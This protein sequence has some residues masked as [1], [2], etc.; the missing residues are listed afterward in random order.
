M[1]M[2]LEMTKR[3]GRKQRM[4]EESKI[5]VCLIMKLDEIELS[6]LNAQ[7]RRDQCKPLATKLTCEEEADVDR[8]VLATE[9]APP[10]SPQSTEEH[11]TSSSASQQGL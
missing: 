1:F 11:L 6:Q 4:E 7:T 5:K 3:K 2:P 10:T 9:T 8:N